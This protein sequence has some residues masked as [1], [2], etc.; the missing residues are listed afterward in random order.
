MLALGRVKDPTEMQTVLDMLSKETARLSSMIE[1]V[2]DWSRIDAGE[3]AYHRE[4]QPVTPVVE[5]AVAAFRASRVG[6]TMNFTVEVAPDLPQ[7]DADRDAISG[8]LL[9]LLQNAFK[10]TGDDKH[11]ALRV[12]NEGGEVIIEVQDNGVGIPRRELKRVFER[13]YRIDSLLTRQ[14]EGS[15]LGLSIALRIVQAHR[16]KITV[17]SAPGKGTTFRLHLPGVNA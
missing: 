9:N 1:K 8:A 13:F 2:L 15:G 7:I 3:R 11:I 10:Y 6:A 16:G 4:L 17:D 5:V 12:V 14:T